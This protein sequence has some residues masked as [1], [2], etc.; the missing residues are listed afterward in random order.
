MNRTKS[1]NTLSLLAY[2]RVRNKILTGEYAIGFPLSRRTLA[3]ELG[4]SLI[5][6]S[7]ALQR[8]EAEGMVESKPRAGTRVRIPTSEDIRGHYIVR[9]ALESQSA[10]L[11][12]RHATREQKNELRE[13]AELVDKLSASLEKVEEPH[14]FAASYE[15]ERTHLRFHTVIAECSNCPALVEAIER[16]RVLI[17]NWLFNVASGMPSLPV[18]WHRDLAKGLC[19][20]DVLDADKIMREHVTHRQEEVLRRFEKL[21]GEGQFDVR[22]VRGPHKR[23]QPLA[24]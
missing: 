23:A 4:M 12:S 19:S 7:E 6:V 15:F 11:F 1:A 21:Q 2:E 18:R 20:G 13:L 17:Y 10:R 22:F 8:L 14:R 3:E 16:S 9:E 5:P 24:G